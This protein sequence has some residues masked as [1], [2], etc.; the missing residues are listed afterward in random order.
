MLTETNPGRCRMDRS[1]ASS[2]AVTRSCWRSGATVN[3][4][5]RVSGLVPS[6]M[7]VIGLS[8]PRTSP[9][10]RH[11]V[12]AVH[13]RAV[14]VGQFLHRLGEPQTGHALEQRA[15]DDLQLQPGQVR[16]DA[17]VQAEAEGD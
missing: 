11:L 2:S 16:A 5:I 10:H 7:T 12:D 4:L 17:V 8:L 3:T 14:L 15:E 13:A 6:R 1:V 9:G